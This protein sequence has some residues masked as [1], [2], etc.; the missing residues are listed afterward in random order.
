MRSRAEVQQ[1]V[2]PVEEPASASNEPFE[3]R[4][5]PSQLSSMKRTIDV[6]QVGTWLTVFAGAYG[7]DHEQRDAA[8]VAAAVVQGADSDCDARAERH[9]IL[10]GVVRTVD[11]RRWRWSYQPPESS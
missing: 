1:A 5:P 6:V 7:E 11:D 9:A 8:G 2:R 3:I 10:I 4:S